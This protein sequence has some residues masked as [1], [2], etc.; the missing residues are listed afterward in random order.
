MNTAF[1]KIE[2]NVTKREMQKAMADT[3]A[4]T[5]NVMGSILSEVSNEAL[6]YMSKKSSISRNLLNYRRT[7]HLPVPID[8]NFEIP[9]KYSEL[10]LHD[11]GANDPNRILVLGVD[12]MLMEL[13]KDAIFG[14]GTF[15]KVPSMFYQLYTRHAQV[16]NSYPPCVYFLLQKKSTDI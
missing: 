5:R 2:V 10:V 15:D 13:N 11:S 16:G 3:S 8:T 6:V 14:D 9:D 4:T 7:G 12:E 1:K